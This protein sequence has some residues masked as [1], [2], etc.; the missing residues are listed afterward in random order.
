MKN[1]TYLLIILLICE[2]SFA[3]TEVDEE[4][5]LNVGEEASCRSLKRVA[6]WLK[7]SFPGAENSPD[8]LSTSLAYPALAGVKALYDDISLM[9]RKVYGD[10]LQSLSK[11]AIAKMSKAGTA[12]LNPS[13][14]QNLAT[15][16]SAF[17]GALVIYRHK[18]L[19][20][21]RIAGGL[22]ANFTHVAGSVDE[23][24]I[25]LAKSKGLSS[26]S[27]DL[28]Y[29]PKIFRQIISEEDFAKLV[30]EKTAEFVKES[31]NHI[32]RQI[33]S[34]L[35][36]SG[37]KF[38]LKDIVKI[39]ESFAANFKA[40]ALNSPGFAKRIIA[41]H[42][43]S[44]GSKLS[45]EWLLR[46]T[47]ANSTVL[48][49]IMNKSIVKSIVGSTS[50][51]LLP[52]LSTCAARVGQLASRTASR[53]LAQT[54]GKVVV[55]GA[56][57][58]GG[59]AARAL[60]M[61][62]TAFTMATFGNIGGGDQSIEAYA[63]NNFDYLFQ[64]INT[65]GVESLCGSRLKSNI[66]LRSQISFLDK[67]LRS[68]EVNDILFEDEQSCDDSSPTSVDQSSVD[69]IDGIDIDDSGDDNPALLE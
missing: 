18:D 31:K 2:T 20:M 38:K 6:Q 40:Q 25:K 3:S 56:K 24:L 30:V 27:R 49:T 52:R 5:V 43:I 67:Y 58:L 62:V 22:T 41:G 64:L 26:M 57:L 4:L 16:A 66:Q 48:E 8:E 60:S 55:G 69:D 28:I 1:I 13:I 11:S 65:E 14:S 45:Y 39:V 10:A 19:V 32:A 50:K 12:A 44:V 9:R 21:K 17:G 42:E 23:A 68:D 63:A 46:T 7:T 61:P 15:T 37:Y 54:A 59:W 51:A 29:R 36:S 34:T 33:R 47:L 35:A 53:P